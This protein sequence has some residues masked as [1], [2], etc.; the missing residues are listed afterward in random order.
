MMCK[1]SVQQCK[2][3]ANVASKSKNEFIQEKY[4]TEI[5]FCLIT[6]YF[7]VIA[8][9]RMHVS[10]CENALP[11]ARWVKIENVNV[12][13]SKPHKV[14]NRQVSLS[15]IMQIEQARKFLKSCCAKCQ[16]MYVLACKKC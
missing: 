13:I 11:Q 5:F 3:M 10:N 4:A 7:V 1:E 15:S 16:Q 2:Y 6:T 8:I 14:A 9:T 12:E